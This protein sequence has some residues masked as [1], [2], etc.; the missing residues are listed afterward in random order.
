MYVVIALSV[1][2]LVVIWLGIAASIIFIPM[3]VIFFIVSEIIYHQNAVSEVVLHHIF[4]FNK[5]KLNKNIEAEI[6]R[7]I[8]TI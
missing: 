6:A 4:L 7:K 1:I 2:C 5:N 3:T 8:R